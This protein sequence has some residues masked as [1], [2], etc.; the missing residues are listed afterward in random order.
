ML[1]YIVY[2]VTTL[3]GGKQ[4]NKKELEYFGSNSFFKTPSKLVGIARLSLFFYLFIVVC[5]T[6]CLLQYAYSLLPS[7]YGKTAVGFSFGL[8]NFFAVKLL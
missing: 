2:I 1:S 8:K 4:V 7:M 5:Q 6:P 3:I